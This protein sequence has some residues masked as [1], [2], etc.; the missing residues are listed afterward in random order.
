MVLIP[1]GEYLMG[2]EHIESYVNERPIHKVKVDSF[3]I[4]VSEVTNFEFSAFVKETGYITTAERI[5]N[6]DKIYSN[7]KNVISEYS[8]GGSGTFADKVKG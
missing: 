7:N 6:W 8:N 3:Y 4:D 1:G 5:I 2:S